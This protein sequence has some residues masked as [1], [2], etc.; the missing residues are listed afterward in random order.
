MKSMPNA[1]TRSGSTICGSTVL[2]LD[3][4]WCRLRHQRTENH[5]IGRLMAPMMATT[6]LQVAR[7]SGSSTKRRSTR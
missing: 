6:A 4:T 5:T 2:G 3:C 1:E 7:L